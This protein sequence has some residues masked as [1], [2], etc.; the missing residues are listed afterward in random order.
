MA[1]D[2]IARAG[3][4][5]ILWPAERAGQEDSDPAAQLSPARDPRSATG[6]AF[7]LGLGIL[8]ARLTLPTPRHKS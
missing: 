4:R 7:S 8:R 6:G 1:E 3:L 2:L 5:A